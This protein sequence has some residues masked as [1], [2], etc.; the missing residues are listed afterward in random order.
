M[1]ITTSTDEYVTV[2]PNG[3]LQVQIVT[4][5]VEDGTPLTSKNWRTTYAPTTDIST[6]TGRAAEIA[7]LMWTQDV[8][9]AYVASLPEET[10]DE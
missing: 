2:L 4:N 9:D 5:Y 10:I 7:T 8:I 3:I 1:A 6:M